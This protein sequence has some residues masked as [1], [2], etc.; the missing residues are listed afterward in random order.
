MKNFRYICV[1]LI[2]LIIGFIGGIIGQTIF[3]TELNNYYD[4]LG[5]ILNFSSIFTGFLGAIIGIV[6]SVDSQ[7][8]IM[9][10]IMNQRLSKYQFLTLILI[11]FVFGMINIFCT[12]TLRLLLNN[13]I[14][15][16]ILEVINYIF[17]ASLICFLLFGMIM[18]IM[19]FV[20][21]GKSNQTKR[22]RVYPK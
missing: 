4:F 2:I 18:I 21:F 16:E 10:S 20:I 13:P 12:I 11:P 5:D 14:N 22:K 9:K 17:L 1:I 8:I 19:C 6:A 3:N 7:S 15:K